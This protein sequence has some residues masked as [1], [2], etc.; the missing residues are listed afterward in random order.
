MI[1]VLYFIIIIYN[2]A[3]WIISACSGLGH[4]TIVLA[5]NVCFAVL[6]LKLFAHMYCTSK[7]VCIKLPWLCPMVPGCW[8]GQW[9]RITTDPRINMVIS[10]I[11][12]Q[13]IIALKLT[14]DY[15]Q[16]MCHMVTL[17]S[18]GVSG[19]YFGALMQCIMLFRFSVMDSLTKNMNAILCLYMFLI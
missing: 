19:S 13:N 3:I 12:P 1:Y 15:I 10:T 11:C 17:S 4:E 2:S 6:W 16:A 7:E 18:E 9:L 5:V 8:P 14:I